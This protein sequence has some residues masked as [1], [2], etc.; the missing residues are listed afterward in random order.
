MMNVNNINEYSI[1]DIVVIAAMVSIYISENV[2]LKTQIRLAS[3]LSAISNNL[4]ISAEQRKKIEGYLSTS[5]D[6]DV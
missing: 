2:D 1:N 4:F 5:P 3:I 6:E